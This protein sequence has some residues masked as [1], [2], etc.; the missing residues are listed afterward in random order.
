MNSTDNGAN[1]LTNKSQPWISESPQKQT[2]TSDPNTSTTKVD[3]N[4]IYST[5][6]GEV[7]LLGNCTWPLEGRKDK[8]FM[9]RYLNPES[10]SNDCN[11]ID[12][13]L[14]LGRIIRNLGVNRQT[15]YE[16]L[17][18]KYPNG[19]MIFAISALID[20]YNKN[21]EFKNLKEHKKYPKSKLRSLV[22]SMESCLIANK[23]NSQEI[24]PRDIYDKL[25]DLILFVLKLTD[26]GKAMDFT[27]LISEENTEEI[28]EVKDEEEKIVLCILN[29]FEKRIARLQYEFF[30]NN[31]HRLKLPVLNLINKRIIFFNRKGELTLSPRYWSNKNNDEKTL[32]LLGKIV[33][34]LHSVLRG[35]NWNDNIIQDELI[36]IGPNVAY[37]RNLLYNK[38][39]DLCKQ[40]NLSNDEKK[41]KLNITHLLFLTENICLFSWRS[42]ARKYNDKEIFTG[43]FTLCNCLLKDHPGMDKELQKVWMKIKDECTPYILLSEVS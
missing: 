27:K 14:L 12:Q 6:V 30:Y 25:F 18:E 31:E 7:L 24:T 42:A 11:I 17:C 8:N 16:K 29:L 28:C 26:V 37:L 22:D 20:G 2:N 35:E 38:L 32:N 15:V 36:A 5:F 10:N 4:E 19:E 3:L 21:T 39:R 34:K 13:E 33:T 23:R 41:D 1:V 9:R 40:N 43:I